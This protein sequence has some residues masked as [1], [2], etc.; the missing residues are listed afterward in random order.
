MTLPAS[1]IPALPADNEPCNAAYESPETLKLLA[2]RRSAKVAHLTAPGPDA[3]QLDA[4]IKLAARVPDHGKLGPWR[5]VIIE[6]DGRARAGAKLADVIAGDAG[7]DDV[8]LKFARETFTRAPVTV[9]VVSNTT[10]P[11]PKV[12]EWEQIQ[13]A[14]A[15][16][17]ALLIAAHAMGFAGVWLTE[18]PAYDERARK[19]LGLAGHERV[20]GFVYLGAS[21]E[22]ATER[23]RADVLA[24]VSRF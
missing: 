12:P 13:S 8:R 5:F 3:S 14:S 20:A 9:M 21:K 2:R 6:G 4:L 11:H 15:A 10:V 17:F 7:V 22:P 16:C 19:A 24:R 18:W 1:A 23:V